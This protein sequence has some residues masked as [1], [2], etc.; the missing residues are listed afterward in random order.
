MKELCTLL[1]MEKTQTCLLRPQGDGMA[2]LLNRTLCDMINTVGTDFPFSWEI[3][4]PLV[5]LAYN[6][7][8]QESTKE[9][10]NA[11]VY[12]CTLYVGRRSVEVESIHSW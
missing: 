11:M 6:S 5:T 3:M 7:S 8:R 1:G 2:E 4:L 9:S 12:G 10:P